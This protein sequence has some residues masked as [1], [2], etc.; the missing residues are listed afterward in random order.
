[1]KHL[2]ALILIFQIVS[3][4][5]LFLQ[6][7]DDWDAYL[8][9]LEWINNK[10]HKKDDECL[11]NKLKQLEEDIFTIHGLWPTFKSGK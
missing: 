11:P 5:L 1:M 7:N 6:D 9:T 3:N 8:L 4:P 2:I 10:C